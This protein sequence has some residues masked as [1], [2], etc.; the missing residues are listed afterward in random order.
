MRGS[1]SLPWREAVKIIGGS[2]SS[3][4]A[5]RRNARVRD[6]LAERSAGLTTLLGVDSALGLI[7]TSTVLATVLSE[8]TSN[9]ASANMVVPVVIAFAA[10]AGIDPRC[11]CWRRRWAPARVPPARIDALQRT[12]SR[13]GGCRSR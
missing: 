10:S 11:P 4:A 2:S 5:S 12:R 3:A 9:T 8:T 13:P 7:A 6:G 1:S